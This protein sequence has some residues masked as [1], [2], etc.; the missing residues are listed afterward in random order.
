MKTERGTFM[1]T[2]KKINPRTIIL[3][4]LFVVFLALTIFFHRQMSK[5]NKGAL[6]T[7]VYVR[8]TDVKISSNPLHLLSVTVSYQGETYKLKG[9]PNSAQSEVEYCMK[10]RSTLSA[11]L[12]DGKL[13][14]DATS[15]Y[16]LPDKLYLGSLAVT[17]LCL[18]L[19]IYPLLQPES[20]ER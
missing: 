7:K 14:Y 8:V 18:C 16:L 1:N 2:K 11:I 13:Y 9:V 20:D 5:Q 6:G 12:Y 10:Y 3:F 15:I 19:I 17:F 4:V